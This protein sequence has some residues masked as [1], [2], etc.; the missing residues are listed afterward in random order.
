VE[1]VKDLP[2]KQEK[3]VMVGGELAIVTCDE[4]SHKYDVKC[5]QYRISFTWHSDT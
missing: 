4:S 3:E 5:Y 2:D 1:E